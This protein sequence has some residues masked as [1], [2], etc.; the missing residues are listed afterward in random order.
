M[1]MTEIL[2]LV[3]LIG[4]ALGVLSKWVIVPGFK[5]VHAVYHAIIYIQH[6]LTYNSGRSVKDGVERMDRRMEYLFKHLGIEIPEYLQS[7]V[8]IDPESTS[9][10]P[11]AHHD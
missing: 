11:G 3:V 6:E 7:P 10:E 2:S 8:L 9:Q 1:T 5:A 4:A